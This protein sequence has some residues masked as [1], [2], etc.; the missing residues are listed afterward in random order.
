M[1]FCACGCDEMP[2]N[3]RLLD[4]SGDVSKTH[5]VEIETD[6]IEATRKELHDCYQCDKILF[7]YDGQ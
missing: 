1:K 3:R 7:N 2:K 5:L 6:D 4:K